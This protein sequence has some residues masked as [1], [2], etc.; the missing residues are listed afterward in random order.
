M[1]IHFTK[2]EYRSLIELL[3]I[4]DWVVTAPAVSETERPKKIC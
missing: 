2:K 1:K 4:A 3:H